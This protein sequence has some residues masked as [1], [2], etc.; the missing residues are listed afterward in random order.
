MTWEKLQIYSKPVQVTNIIIEPSNTGEHFILYGRTA[1]SAKSAFSAPKGIVLTLDFTT[2]H[3]RACQLPKRPNTPESDYE[4]YTPNGHISPDCLMGHKTT[5]VRRKRDAQCFNSET[6]DAWYSF[7]HCECT[8]EDWECDL[9]FE[10]R[11][12]GPCENQLEDE[13]SYEP[14]EECNGQFYYVTQGYRKVAGNTCEGGVDHSPKKL[15]CPGKGFTIVNAMVLVILCSIIA[16]IVLLSNKGHI[17]KA[18]ELAKNIGTKAKSTTGAGFSKLGFKK[19]GQDEP[20]SLNDDDDDDDEFD[21]RL[22]FDD[23]DE[24]AQPLEDRNLMD[25]VKGGKK[26]AGRSALDTAQKS[27]P[28]VSQPG[29]SGNEIDLIEMK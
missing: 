22:R 14:P 20:G 11:G 21:N 8:E 1:S 26:M 28:K 23:H 12:Q 24:P 9:G 4:T 13:I 2:L 16:A 3:E 7:S 6:F 19:M 25:V 18:K 10:R 5:Y 29:S 15:P 17:N 27:I